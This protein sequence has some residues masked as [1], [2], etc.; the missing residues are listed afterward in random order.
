MLQIITYVPS[1]YNTN[2][3]IAPMC[4]GRKQKTAKFENLLAS[5]TIYVYLRIGEEK[6]SY[7]EEIQYRSLNFDNTLQRLLIIY[8]K[9]SRLIIMKGKV[10]IRTKFY[11]FK[12]VKQQWRSRSKELFF[13]DRSS[14]LLKGEKENLSATY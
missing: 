3:Y 4:N 1:I 10:F 11:K 2:K 5:L 13:I 7:L 8:F 6:F 9:S 12:V 14:C